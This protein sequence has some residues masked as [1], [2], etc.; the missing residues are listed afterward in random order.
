[1]KRCKDSLLKPIE[2]KNYSKL[3]L[4]NHDY[5][6]IFWLVLRYL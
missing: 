3:K 5:K 2:I 1:M 4:F 6:D